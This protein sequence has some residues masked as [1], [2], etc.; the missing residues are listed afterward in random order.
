MYM[1]IKHDTGKLRHDLL[2]P[3][4]EDAMAYVATIGADK[5]GDNNWREDGGLGYGQVIRALKGHFNKWQRGEKYDQEDGQH[6]LGSVG[7]CAMA[8][9]YME[10]YGIGNDDRWL[11]GKPTD[12]IEQGTG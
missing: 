3:E 4:F 5:Y 6:H 12:G 2:C 8:L 10:M 9:Y 1:G 7:W 11:D